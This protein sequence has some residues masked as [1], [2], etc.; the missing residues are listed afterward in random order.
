MQVASA[1]GAASRSEG[2]LVERIEVGVDRLAVALEPSPAPVARAEAGQRLGREVHARLT[3]HD[4]L[5]HPLSDQERAGDPEGVAPG[6]RV[7]PVDGRYLPDQKVPVG[8]EGRKTRAPSYDRRRLEGRKGARE[9]G[10]EL[11]QDSL[12][13]FGLLDRKRGREVGHGEPLGRSLEADRKSTRL[14]SSHL[15]ISYA[16]FCLKKKKII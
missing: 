15:V 12:V 14:N 10:A 5:A 7:E 4:Q 2:P 3:V 1:I 6:G 9:S 8:R 13:T 16:V 11:L